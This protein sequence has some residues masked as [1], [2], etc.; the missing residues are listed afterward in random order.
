MKWIAYGKEAAA[1][2]EILSE[3]AAICLM[4]LNCYK[5][6]VPVLHLRTKSTFISHSYIGSTLAARLKE[7]PIY[8]LLLD[9]NATPEVN[10]KLPWI[11]RKRIT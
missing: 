1:I 7:Q 9:I 6:H 8:A 11:T 4:T 2:T 3:P 5:K 10:T